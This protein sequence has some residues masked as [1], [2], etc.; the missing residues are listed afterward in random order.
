MWALL[1]KVVCFVLAF[2]SVR[3]VLFY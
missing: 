3:E 2:E 1:L